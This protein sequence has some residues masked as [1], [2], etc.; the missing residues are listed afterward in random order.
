MDFKFVTRHRLF[1]TDDFWF[2]VDEYERGGDQMLIAHVRVVRWSPSVRKELHRVWDIFR[3]C[4][5][6]PIYTM[7][8]VDDDKFERF[9]RGFGYEPHQTITC[10]N[11]ELRRLFIH[12]LRT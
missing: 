1:T 3:Q 6:A 11:G 7:G 10:A 2:D 12:T 9:V 4:V 8:E 5:P